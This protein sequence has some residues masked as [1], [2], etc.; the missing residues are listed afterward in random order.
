MRAANFSKLLRESMLEFWSALISLADMDKALAIDCKRK[1]VDLL[2]ALISKFVI[3]LEKL[4]TLN[5][6]AKCAKCL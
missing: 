4:S 1:V 3:L 2:Q 5:H 6:L